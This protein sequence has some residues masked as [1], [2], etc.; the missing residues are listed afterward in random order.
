MIISLHK[1]LMSAADTA[2]I[3]KSSTQRNVPQ[4]CAFRL[5]LSLVAQSEAV[6]GDGI[7]N[8]TSI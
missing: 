7:G 2:P 1:G 4:L 8:P 6:R 5:L 3:R